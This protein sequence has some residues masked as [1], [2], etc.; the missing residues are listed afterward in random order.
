M[1]QREGRVRTDLTSVA[2]PIRCIFCVY[3]IPARFL[4]LFRFGVVVTSLRFDASQLSL[5][6]LILQMVP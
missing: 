1:R 6:L 3:R 5:H 4:A 2:L